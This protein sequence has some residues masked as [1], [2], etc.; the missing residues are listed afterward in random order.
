M[1]KQPIP[2]EVLFEI[3]RR[4]PYKSVNKLATNTGISASVLYKF[5]RGESFRL[6]VPTLL[7]LAEIFPNHEKLFIAA[8]QGKEPTLPTFKPAGKASA[9]TPSRKRMPVSKSAA[10]KVSAGSK[11]SKAPTKR[12]TAKKSAGKRAAS[13]TRKPSASASRATKR[14]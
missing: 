9:A 5:M 8:A 11:K 4:S 1:A 14:R 10:K 12:T 13:A 3:L 6:Y 7:R 2:P